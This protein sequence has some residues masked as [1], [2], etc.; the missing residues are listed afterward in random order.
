MLRNIKFLTH[1][2]HCSGT[3]KFYTAQDPQI[4]TT[5]LW[6]RIQNRNPALFFCGLQDANINCFSHT[7][8]FLFTV[9]IQYLHLQ[10]HY[11]VK[12]KVFP[13]SFFIVH[14]R[15]RI[16]AN[17]I[18]FGSSGGPKLSDPSMEVTEII[19]VKS[20]DFVSCR[21]TVAGFLLGYRLLKPSLW[22]SLA[23]KASS[24]DTNM[25]PKVV[26]HKT[27]FVKFKISNNIKQN[28]DE[29]D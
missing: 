22:I 13:N 29:T 14:G 8:F 20:I 10:S 26:F 11:T 12:M 3:V 21:V 2:Y 16:R 18:G 6:I 5:W 4:I 9:G 23:H 28:F 1:F 7:I 15:I 24:Y 17:N 27:A 19:L 25:L